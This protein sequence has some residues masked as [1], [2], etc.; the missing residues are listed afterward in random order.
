[1]RE[2]GTGTL[3]YTTG[4]GSVNP[5]PEIGNVNV[6]AAALRNWVLN[7]NTELSGCGGTGGPIRGAMIG[8]RR[9]SLRGGC[10]WPCRRA[11]WVF[12]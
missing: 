11:R 2:A 3:L 10:R 8:A 9:A 1:M 5:V 12:R 4:A 6:A 7:L